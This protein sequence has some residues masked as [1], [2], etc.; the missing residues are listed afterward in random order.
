LLK[1]EGTTHTRAA[2]TALAYKTVQK[3]TNSSYH[4]N[5]TTHNV[6]QSTNIHKSAWVGTAAADVAAVTANAAFATAQIIVISRFSHHTII[7][8]TV[9]PAPRYSHRKEGMSLLF[10][11]VIRSSPSSDV[12]SMPFFRRPVKSRP[13]RVG[14]SSSEGQQ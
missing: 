8:H 1:Q 11:T 9:L 4:R 13:P 7:I 3:Y 12:V 14:P 6:S 5:S 2:S 10:Q